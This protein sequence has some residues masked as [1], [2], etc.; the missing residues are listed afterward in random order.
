MKT[1]KTWVEA[2]DLIN[3][4]TI[5]DD[6]SLNIELLSINL[7]VR[8]TKLTIRKNYIHGFLST[9]HESNLK[10]GN[11]LKKI[12]LP[13]GTEFKYYKDSNNICV[14]YYK[15][16]GKKYFI[17][18]TDSMP[19]NFIHESN[20]YFLKP[21][22]A[23]KSINYIGFNDNNIEYEWL[24]NSSNH[25]INYES[26]D[27][28]NVESYLKLNINNPFI[29]LTSFPDEKHFTIYSPGR[30]Y[31]M[32]GSGE[33]IYSGVRREHLN[34]TV[35]KVLHKKLKQHPELVEKLID[36][37]D[38]IL[39]FDISDK[40]NQNMSDYHWGAVLEGD[41]LLGYNHL[42]KIWMEI[43]NRIKNKINR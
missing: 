25:R 39:Y 22:K 3:S 9:E 8:T 7:C 10:V 28:E 12:I 42:G 33:S 41:N 37:K 27:Y 15:R 32:M 13:N 29:K 19:I 38:N 1:I 18:L 14:N 11:N 36:T 31:T 20:V 26:L 17:G 30:P 23:N 24:S 16:S 5:L 4:K 6:F 40:I 2:I 43:R 21:I 34:V 35:K